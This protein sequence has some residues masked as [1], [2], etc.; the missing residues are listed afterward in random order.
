[1]T[2]A[3]QNERLSFT[4]NFHYSGGKTFFSSLSPETVVSHNIGAKYRVLMMNP[5][6][7]QFWTMKG[8]EEPM[9]QDE[10]NDVIKER[11]RGAL[12]GTEFAFE[13]YDSTGDRKLFAT[14]FNAQDKIPADGH[15]SDKAVYTSF[16]WVFDLPEDLKKLAEI[17]EH[18]PIT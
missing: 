10:I 7:N 9:T 13:V 18:S 1:M 12:C 6:D 15:A 3:S 11:H 8:M 17:G 16:S 14:R 4:A 2:P 5:N